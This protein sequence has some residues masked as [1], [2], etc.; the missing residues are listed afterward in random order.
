MLLSYWTIPYVAI[1]D[2]RLVYLYNFGFVAIFSWLCF[3]VF[4]GQ[5]YLESDRLQG[6]A[7]LRLRNG[8]T[9]SGGSGHDS[10]GDE[11]RLELQKTLSSSGGFSSNNSTN[12]FV[13]ASTSTSAGSLLVAPCG[14]LFES[15]ILD[16]EQQEHAT[17]S[18]V[19]EH[20]NTATSRL[21]THW[22]ADATGRSASSELFVV[23]RI[24]DVVEKCEYSIPG[25]GRGRT[26]HLPPSSGGPISSSP[27]DSSSSTSQDGDSNS[28]DGGGRGNSIHRSAV[29]SAP[30]G[31][32]KPPDE[33]FHY[34]EVDDA[35]CPVPW[36]RLSR[37]DRYVANLPDFRVA[38]TA[39]AEAVEFC[40]EYR[41]N[42]KRCPFLYST[43][44][45]AVRGEFLGFDGVVKQPFPTVAVHLAEDPHIGEAGRER[46]DAGRADER[47][48][49]KN[50]KK[51]KPKTSLD[52]S[53]GQLLSAAGIDSL[54]EKQP[55]DTVVREKGSVL[56]L[57][58]HFAPDE[59]QL[60][61]WSSAIDSNRNRSV[62]AKYTAT[63]DR[64]PFS[65]YKLREVQ[66]IA[67]SKMIS[68]K[69]NTDSS[70]IFTTP[71][72]S[73]GNIMGGA[74]SPVP[75]ISHG[76]E[77]DHPGADPERRP[78]HLLPNKH[79]HFRR[80]RTL[81][82]IQIKVVLAGSARR[83]SWAAVVSQAV[84]KF[85]LLGLLS[86]GLDLLWQYVFP[87]VVGV[88]YSRQVYSQVKNQC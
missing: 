40:S 42:R 63:V 68:G 6:V 36:T 12:D 47:N 65:E 79:S 37:K 28:A 84:L 29:S 61:F 1:P 33:S 8:P 11:K 81:H 10:G 4:V 76:P 52:V 23:T 55:D 34:Q 43:T 22:D 53:L 51:H 30:A 57:T 44:D 48:K 86:Q 38:V 87:L 80:V 14:R 56:V 59:E 45:P 41:K 16:G 32:F 73:D 3:D 49:K 62:P 5:S 77:D 31:Y 74:S 50:S 46:S 21:C 78:P 58:L 67:I 64:I 39:H 71:S 35:E 18:D 25:A 19:V 70:R 17:T 27:T 83:F 15:A 2:A 54:D 69:M 24:K 72:E 9:A 20:Q 13:T 66:P 60:S 26:N 88:D 85:G 82:G 75:E 7:R